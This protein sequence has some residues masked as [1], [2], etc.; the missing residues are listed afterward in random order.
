MVTR[1]RTGKPMTS[2]LWCQTSRM[3]TAPLGTTEGRGLFQVMVAARGDIVDGVI[4]GD[5]VGSR[6]VLVLDARSGEPGWPVVH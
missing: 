5:L 2:L 6:V 4:Q 1:P 3:A